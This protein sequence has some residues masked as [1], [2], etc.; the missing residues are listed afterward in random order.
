MSKRGLGRGL[1][2]L[3]AS[4]GQEHEGDTTQVPIDQIQPN[5]RQPRTD[6]NEDA[7]AELADSIGKVGLV[8]PILCRPYGEGYQII[9]GER[10]WRAAR[11]A[12]LERVPVIVKTTTDA[13]ALALALI[14]NLLREDLNPVEEARGYRRLL[15]EHQM[16]QA[17][18]AE[19]VSKSRPAITNALRLLDLPDDVQEMIYSGQ[20]T[21]GHARAI[22]AVP[23]EGLRSRLAAKV[24]D[25]G[26][27]VRATE[28]LA[29]LYA[30]GKTERAPRPP[31]PQAFRVVARKLRRTLGTNVRVRQTPKKGKIEIDFHSEDDLERIFRI[32][33]G[34]APSEGGTQ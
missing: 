28:E 10:R 26:L 4:G 15:T 13:E 6:M 1:S 33:T 20:L 24:R 19:S 8:Q 25:E 34:E 27:S 16:T 29:R 7:I 21:A 22:L 30:A 11:V 9:A 2:A 3:I 31:A 18:L 14:E 23:E 12:G 32:L 17:E 5:P